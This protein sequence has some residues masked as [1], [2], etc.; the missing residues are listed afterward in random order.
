[1]MTLEV[2]TR[3][4]VAL[5]KLLCNLRETPRQSLSNPRS[6]IYMGEQDGR[7]RKQIVDAVKQLAKYHLDIWKQARLYVQRVLADVIERFSQDNLH[8][9]WPIVLT[10]WHELLRPEMDSTSFS[11]DM[12]TITS[13][14][15]PVFEG[16]KA[17]RNR[18]IDGLFALFDCSSTAGEK[19]EVVSALREATRLPGRVNSSNELFQLTLEDT[20]RITELL[21][22]RAT[23]QPYELLEHIEYIMLFDY[24]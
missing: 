11:A 23:G 8:M 10:V 13:G 24:W 3:R 6:A 2:C 5:L 17:I 20:K 12:V 14:A 15:L 4:F 9:L 7:V 16:L 18:A 22:R 21:T 19:R 1:M